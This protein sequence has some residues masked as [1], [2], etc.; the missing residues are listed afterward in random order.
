[1]V[2]LL[3]MAAMV[4]KIYELRLKRNRVLQNLHGN[5][6]AGIRLQVLDH[7]I[8]CLAQQYAHARREYN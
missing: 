2:L 5:R 7:R 8:R 4:A 6:S 1:M 3:S